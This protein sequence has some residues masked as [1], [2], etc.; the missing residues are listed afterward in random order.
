MTLQDADSGFDRDDYSHPS[1]PGLESVWFILSAL[2]VSLLLSL[3]PDLVSTELELA[4][5]LVAVVM[6]GLPHGALDPWI[7]R[8]AGVF[9]RWPGWLAFNF[10]YLV[11]ATLM[12]VLWWLLPVTALAVFLALSVWHFSGDWSTTLPWPARLLTSSGLIVLPSFF[13]PEAVAAIFAALSG[14]ESRI[15][16]DGLAAAGP[17]VL[18]GMVGVMLLAAW[19]RHWS[20]VFE[21]GAIAL[22]AA[23]A[24]P[25]V[26]FVLY[27]CLLHSPRHMGHE[28]RVAGQSLRP[29]LLAVATAYT[30]ATLIIG[31]VMAWFLWPF[32]ATSD[33]ILKLVFIGLAAL[34]VPH[35][36]LI[37]YR[38]W[39]AL[40]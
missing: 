25:L 37:L 12:L 10:S 26:F 38:R 18:A 3:A 14:P 11:L 31:G 33:L 16:A 4:V 20:T 36:A 24:S 28:L 7:A 8:Q 32:I 17:L 27:F 39:P 1:K 19:Q 29:R 40:G 30:V 34:T 13:H 9:Q 15:I 5:L 2:S 35:M 6:L 22:L 23:L 21:V